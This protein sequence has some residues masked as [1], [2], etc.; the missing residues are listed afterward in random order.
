MSENLF[1]V[2]SS[3]WCLVNSVVNQK[4]S[5]PAE[6]GIS[7]LR[8]YVKLYCGINSRKLISYLAHYCIASS[9]EECITTILCLAVQSAAQPRFS[10]DIQTLL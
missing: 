1:S 2:R 3:V 4:I 9:H 7:V 5:W 8:T 6:L 10:S